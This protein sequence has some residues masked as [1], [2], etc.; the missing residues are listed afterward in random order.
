MQSSVIVIV[1]TDLSSVGQELSTDYS[2]KPT[3]TAII[4]SQQTTSSNSE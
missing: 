2:P 1:T 3:S 4:I